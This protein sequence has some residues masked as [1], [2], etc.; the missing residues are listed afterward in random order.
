MGVAT[1]DA[2]GECGEGILV[3]NTKEVAAVRGVRSALPPPWPFYTAHTGTQVA[4]IGS[5]GPCRSART[6]LGAS[7]IPGLHGTSLHAVGL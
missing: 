7:S 3:D 5:E 6:G 1:L 4:G 2:L